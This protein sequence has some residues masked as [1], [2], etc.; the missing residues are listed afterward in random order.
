MNGVLAGAGVLR[1]MRPSFPVG[2][3]QQRVFFAKGPSIG[4]TILPGIQV[5]V[6]FGV[7]VRVM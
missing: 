6:L 2:R 3:L 5:S 7:L 1:F 4:E